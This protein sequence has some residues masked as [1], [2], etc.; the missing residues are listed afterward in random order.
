MPE[1][2]DLEAIQEE[3]C[4][5]V[6]IVSDLKNDLRGYVTASGHS[7]NYID[8]LLN[9]TSLQALLLYIK[10]AYNLDFKG[11]ES[12]GAHDMISKAVREHATDI[13]SFLEDVRKANKR[14]VW[15]KLGIEIPRTF[16]CG[17]E[18]S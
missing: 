3:K 5:A 11:I 6:Y 2:K 7:D 12:D 17:K 14:L 10:P 4:I 13:V 8:K 16:K 1:H 18:A 15:A 9:Y